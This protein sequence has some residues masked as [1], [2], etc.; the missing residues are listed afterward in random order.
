L[1]ALATVDVIEVADLLPEIE[2][3]VG[4]QAGGI[5]P[6]GPDH[7]SFFDERPARGSGEGDEVDRPVE[8]QAG[9]NPDGLDRRGRLGGSNDARRGPGHPLDGR[10]LKRGSGG[11]RHHESDEVHPTILPRN[12]APAPI[13]P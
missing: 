10:L 8:G 5:V 6:E 12:L 9:K 13:S 4:F 1:N 11:E 3:E 7:A 2:E